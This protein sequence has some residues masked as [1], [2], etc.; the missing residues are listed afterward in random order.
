MINFI[1]ITFCNIFIFII[2]LLK[3][4]TKLVFMIMQILL[5]IMSL[6]TMSKRK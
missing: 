5:F 4:A 2:Y 3:I 6:F 1:K